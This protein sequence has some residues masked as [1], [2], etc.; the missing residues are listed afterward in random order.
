MFN[1]LPLTTYP[2]STKRDKNMKRN[3]GMIE[4]GMWQEKRLK[5]K[6]EVW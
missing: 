1:G 4:F 6:Q 5:K 2:T 3:I